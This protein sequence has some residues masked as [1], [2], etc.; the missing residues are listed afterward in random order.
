MVN[1][2][3]KE[4]DYVE[5]IKSQSGSEGH[6]FIISK[7]GVKNLV[8]EDGTLYA[9]ERK[10]YKTDLKTTSIGNFKWSEESNLKLV[11]PDTDAISKSSFSEIINEISNFSLIT[12]Q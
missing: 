11:N 6:R 1:F 7:F 3:F 9:K 4:G 8:N 5:I 10:S 12:E 2:K